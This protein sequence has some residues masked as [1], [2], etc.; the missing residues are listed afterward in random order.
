MYTSS[1]LNNWH[2]WGEFQ[3]MI[4]KG[5]ECRTLPVCVMFSKTVDKESNLHCD[6]LESVR[7]GFQGEIYIIHAFCGSNGKHRNNFVSIVRTTKVGQNATIFFNWVLSL[8]HGRHLS[9]PHERTS[10]LEFPNILNISLKRGVTISQ[11]IMQVLQN[12]KSTTG[13]F[14][15]FEKNKGNFTCFIEDIQHGSFECVFI[16]CFYNTGCLHVL[17]Q[18]I[19]MMPS[20]GCTLL[21]YLHKGD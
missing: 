1:H 8:M 19:Y 11:C 21:Q 10:H 4:H 12:L 14:C 13:L 20:Y 9:Y 18:Y 5:L 15:M 7:N 16:A 6:K 2:F 17:I 3:M